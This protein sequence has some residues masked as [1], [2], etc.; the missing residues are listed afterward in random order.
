MNTKAGLRNTWR[1]FAAPVEQ[2]IRL[3]RG[4]GLD[5]E[6]AQG[7]NAEVVLVVVE[8]IGGSGAHAG[9]RT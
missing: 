6:V 8:A 4:H 3:C 1:E 2:P 9:L 7:D 5:V